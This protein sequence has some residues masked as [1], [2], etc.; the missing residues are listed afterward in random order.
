MEA[1]EIVERNIEHA[2]P[3]QGSAVHFKELD[4]DNKLTKDLFTSPVPDDGEAPLDMIVA[5]DC[6]YNSDSRSVPDSLKPT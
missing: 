5:A 2:K 4:W 1:A 3:A 6:T